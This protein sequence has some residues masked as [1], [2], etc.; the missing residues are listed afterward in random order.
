MSAGSRRDRFLTVYGRMPVLEALGSTDL[1]VDR[2]FVAEGAGGDGLDRILRA[3]ADRRVAVEPVTVE[4]LGALARNGRHHQGVAADIE[5]PNLAHLNTFLDRR[6]H[7]RAHRTAVVVLDSVHNPSNVGMVIRSVAA[8]GLEG[9]VVPDRGT[10]EL[11]PLVFKASA[12]VAF[13][14]PVLRCD[15]TA[16]ALAA[17]VDARFEIVGLDAT[18]P[19]A[20]DLFTTALPERA[21]YVLGNEADG[22]SPVTRSVVDRWL[23]IPLHGGVESLN[24]ASAATLVAFE[25][26]R[27]RA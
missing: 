22:L 5:A 17:L 3:A 24:V 13:T 15:T 12:G 16:D 19:G 6:S 2:V 9:I 26:A 7:G 11:G 10:A 20:E 25:V 1:A 27:R 18:E 8:A 14:A 21:A 23:R 4:R